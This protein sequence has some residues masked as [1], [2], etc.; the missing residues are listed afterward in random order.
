MHCLTKSRH[1]AAELSVKRTTVEVSSTKTPDR[2]ERDRL[3]ASLPKLPGK[4]CPSATGL[5]ET[6]TTDAYDD[7]VEVDP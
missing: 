7:G 6:P 1:E 4:T 5:G 3:G 2:Q